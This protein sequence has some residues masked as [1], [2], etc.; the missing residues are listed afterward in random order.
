MHNKLTLDLGLGLGGSGLLWDLNDNFTTDVAAGDVNGTAPEPGPGGNRTLL[1]T[2]SRVSI[3]SEKLRVAGGSWGDPVFSF[4]DSHDRVKGKILVFK[5]KPS[6]SDDV[7]FIGWK[8]TVG[9]YIYFYSSLWQ[10]DSGFTLHQTEVGIWQT[11]ALILRTSG[12][13]WL[14]FFDGQWHLLYCD[15]VDTT[16]SFNPII[17]SGANTE[18]NVDFMRI[19]QILWTPRPVVADAFAGTWPTTDGGGLTGLEAG[20]SDKTWVADI[21]TWGIAAGKAACSELA[22][23]QGV[24]TVD[25]GKTDVWLEAKATRAAGNV[26]VVLNYVNA[27]NHI[28]AYHDGTNV[29]FDLLTT[30]G[31]TENKLSVVIEYAA[32][33]RIMVRSIGTEYRVYYNITH[34]GSATI[35]DATVRAATKHGLYTTNVGNTLDD[36]VGYASGSGG[37]YG[38]LSAFIN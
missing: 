25:C 28:R 3:T 13:F 11:A 2:A 27:T 9:C 26:G 24:A 36:V 17:F 15:F 6:D 35:S 37:E 18:T 1:G 7:V 31:G 12:M 38:F 34:V 32:G 33:A 21:G 30:A 23:G 14:G 16:A 20:G 10:R 29:K 5:I 8:M 22:D 4:A 19:P